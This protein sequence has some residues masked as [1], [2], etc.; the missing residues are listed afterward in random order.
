[1]LVLRDLLH[2]SV[3][4]TLR[5]PTVYFSSSL[6]LSGTL[7]RLSSSHITTLEFA[8]D[9][10]MA[11]VSGYSVFSPRVAEAL[12]QWKNLKKLECHYHWIGEVLHDVR[13]ATTI[14]DVQ[15]WGIHN[16]PILDVTFG[17]ANIRGA[18]LGWVHFRRKNVHAE[19]HQVEM[20]PYL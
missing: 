7:A 4:R 11:S 20:H 2:G 8:W 19:W 1:M 10:W 18:V 17:H 12:L 5:L 13:T 14:A 16:T 9:A 3:A 6:V 15:N